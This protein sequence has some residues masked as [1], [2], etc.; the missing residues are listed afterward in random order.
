MRS[1]DSQRDSDVSS[2]PIVRPVRDILGENV[3]PLRVIEPPPRAT[4]GK[5]T[6]GLA[7]AQ[8]KVILFRSVLYCLI[9]LF[10]IYSFI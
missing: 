2:P 6:D 8:V 7:N 4:V 5:S 1:P 3:S 10:A 9:L